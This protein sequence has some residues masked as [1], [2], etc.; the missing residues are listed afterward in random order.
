ML[1]DTVQI[2]ERENDD[3]TVNACSYSCNQFQGKTIFYKDASLGSRS[4]LG[5]AVALEELVPK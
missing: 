5:S 3:A 2:P 1:G 4:A